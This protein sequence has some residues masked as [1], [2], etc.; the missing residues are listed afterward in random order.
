MNEGTLFICS[1]RS[2]PLVWFRAVF[3]G[4]QEAIV[5]VPKVMA[6]T[7]VFLLAW[8]PTELLSI[9]LGSQVTQT[10]AKPVSWPHPAISQE[11]VNKGKFRRQYSSG[12]HAIVF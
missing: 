5:N 6:E 12:N 8:N 3:G 10:E 4:F 1:Y 11:G 7:S 9:G 2:D